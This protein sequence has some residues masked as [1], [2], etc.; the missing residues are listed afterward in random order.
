LVLPLDKS[1]LYE[2]L[3]SMKK[4]WCGELHVSWRRFADEFISH[5]YINDV[6]RD[7]VK[8]ER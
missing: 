4:A 8:K 7:N 5:I 2:D 6:T 1:K 3:N